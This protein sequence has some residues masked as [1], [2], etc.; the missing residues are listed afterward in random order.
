M[1]S[2]QINL[3]E[4]IVMVFFQ[5]IVARFMPFC[6]FTANKKGKTNMIHSIKLIIIRNNIL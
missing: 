6:I 5:M 4:H 2:P 1:F 3:S